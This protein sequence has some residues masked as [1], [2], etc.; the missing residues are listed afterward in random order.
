MYYCEYATSFGAFHNDAYV[1]HFKLCHMNKVGFYP[2]SFDPF[3]LGHLS[4]VCEALCLFD[5]V[6][7]AIGHNPAKQAAFSV[8]VRKKMI[9]DALDDLVASADYSELNGGQM[10]ASERQ[11]VARI[12]EN[13][14]VVRIIDYEGLTID[15]ALG[16]GA[17]AL[18]RGERIIGDHD[19]EMQLSMLN[20]H[21]LEARHRHLNTVTIPVPKES[22]TYISSS[23][24]KSLFAMG[25]YIAAMR[26]V[27]PSVHNAMCRKYLRKDFPDEYFMSGYSQKVD[28]IYADLVEAYNA[29][30]RYYHNLSHIAYCLNYLNF[31]ERMNPGYFKNMD[32]LKLA[33]FFHDIVNGEEDS[34]DKSAKRLRYLAEDDSPEVMEAARLIGATRYEDMDIPDSAE[35][36]VMRDLDLLI[37]A[38]SRNYGR[39]A[40]Q[41]CREYVP[42]YQREVYAEGR[43]EFLTKLLGQKIFCHK[44]FTPL[45]EEARRNIQKELAVWL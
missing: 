10:S 12:R 34:E 19:A 11:A 36:K 40:E 41:V 45:E 25:E 30:N 20:A 43:K 26:F 21:L 22:L 14:D 9:K 15:A 17:G 32:S 28:Y 27:T 2:G 7:I 5:Q 31:L 24:V 13:A 3:T 35:A 33:V 29:P 8:E 4:I 16:N 38:D 1:K 23:C 6:I 37:L 18:I 39:Y 42:K 44:F